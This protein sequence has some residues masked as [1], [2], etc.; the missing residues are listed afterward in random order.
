VTE[1]D[2]ET[3]E[4]LQG[5]YSAIQRND[6]DELRLNLAHD[7]EWTSPETL[8]WGGTRHGHSG[9]AAFAELFAEEV[10]GPWSEPDD[11]YASDNA[12]IVL[13]RLRGK[14]HATGQEFEVPFAHVWDFDDGMPHR[15]RAYF[16]A[17]PIKAA[18]GR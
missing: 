11:F 2:E 14:G 18:L 4:K 8:P 7:I 13:G 16:D 5:I 17:A 9:V 3:V 15:F 1:V 6:W 12:V 10:D